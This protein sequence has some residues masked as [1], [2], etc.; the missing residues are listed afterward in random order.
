MDFYGGEDFS[1]HSVCSMLKICVCWCF[2]NSHLLLPKHVCM[3]LLVE[4]VH[5][6]EPLYHGYHGQ[7]DQQTQVK[8]QVDMCAMY[9]STLSLDLPETCMI[10]Q[11]HR[12]LYLEVSALMGRALGWCSSP[13]PP[14]AE[15]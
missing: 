1:L 5:M 3:A 10:I 12:D 14:G 4:K 7:Q 8:T 13:T 11:T 2:Q 6:N 15:V 9:F